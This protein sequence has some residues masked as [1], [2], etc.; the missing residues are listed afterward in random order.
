M[1]TCWSIGSESLKVRPEIALMRQAGQIA[2]AMM[3]RAIETIEPGVRECDVAAAV[4]HQMISGTPEFGG[5]Y[6]CAPPF[7]CV[8]ERIIEPHPIW[9]DEPLAP[10]TT[11]NLELFGVRHRYQVNL[12]RSISVGRPSAAYHKLSEIAVEALNAGLE[13]VRPGLTCEEVAAFFT[14]SLARHGLEKEA[15]LGY[16]IGVGFPPGGRGANGQSA[17]GRQDYPPARHGVPHDARPLAR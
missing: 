10:S 8:G 11:I 3:Q 4:Y 6:S 1:P 15:R 9:T 16:S 14:E 5:S 12:S 13:S 2:D 7:L 17:Q